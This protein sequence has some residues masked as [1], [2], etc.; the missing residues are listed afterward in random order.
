M[1]CAVPPAKTVADVVPEVVGPTVAAIAALPLIVSVCGELGA[2]SVITSDVVRI[3]EARG[4]NMME[5][6]QLAFGASVPT[7]LAEP[8]PKSP[9][10]RLLS[11]TFVTCKSP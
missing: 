7:Q 3:P 6:A 5:I 2:S 9:E 10:L 8:K 1:Y 4:E 11:T